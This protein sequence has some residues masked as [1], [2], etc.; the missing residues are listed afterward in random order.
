MNPKV[1]TVLKKFEGYNVSRLIL[2]KILSEDIATLSVSLAPLVGLGVEKL[3]AENT[4]SEL[5]H[6][7][8]PKH[9]IDL[10]SLPSE[11]SVYVWKLAEIKTA[12][13]SAALFKTG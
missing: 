13:V 6:H 8:G 5:I 10:F 11:E 12:S 4:L 9:V 1:R 3:Q 2:V 7:R